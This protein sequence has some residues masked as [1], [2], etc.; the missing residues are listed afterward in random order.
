MTP[1][2]PRIDPQPGDKIRGGPMMRRVI[3]REGDMLG[4]E[5]WGKRYRMRLD[6]WQKW[7]KE[8]GAEVVTEANKKE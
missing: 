3:R 4:C 8:S 1:R 7:C 6:N 2:D 5:T